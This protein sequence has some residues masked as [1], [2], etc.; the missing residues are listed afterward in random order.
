VDELFKLP[1]SS[2]SSESSKSESQETR[3]QAD[4]RFARDCFAG[5][6][7]PE[8]APAFMDL[9]SSVCKVYETLHPGK[10]ADMKALCNVFM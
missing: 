3:A 5:E 10:K 6:T 4:I 1:E 7:Q 8:L 2:E 9:L